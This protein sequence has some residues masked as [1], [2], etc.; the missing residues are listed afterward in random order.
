[1]NWRSSKVAHTVL[2]PIHNHSSSFRY[3]A[4]L[5]P[6]QIDISTPPPPFQ[7]LS[8]DKLC[9]NSALNRTAYQLTYQ[10]GK[11]HHHNTGISSSH[12]WGVLIY[13]LSNTTTLTITSASHSQNQRR[14]MHTHTHRQT[15]TDR[16]WDR[17]TH[18]H[19]YTQHHPMSCSSWDQ[20]AV[21]HQFFP[22][23]LGKMFEEKI[24]ISD[25]S[26]KN[27]LG[28]WIFMYSCLSGYH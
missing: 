14:A 10:Y 27:H 13:F 20:H 6:P 24:Y 2:I 11:L 8:E 9:T 15:E 7:Y 23:G 12:Q 28:K 21:K 22:V 3:G 5:S 16:H 17:H 26:K 25:A 18:T 19:T 1:M 4:T